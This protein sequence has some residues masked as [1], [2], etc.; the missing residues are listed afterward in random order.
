LLIS[1]REQGPS[2][3]TRAREGVLIRMNELQMDE[4][5]VGREER[6]ARLIL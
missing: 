4:L 3:D 1:E 6:K 5:V 2:R